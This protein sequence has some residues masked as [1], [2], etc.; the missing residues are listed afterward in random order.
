MPK[1]AKKGAVYPDRLTDEERVAVRSWI[2]RRYPHL[3]SGALLED[4]EER[5]LDKYRASGWEPCKDWAAGMRNW[6]RKGIEFG[7]VAPTS[8][9]KD[10]YA[11]YHKPA[12]LIEDLAADLASGKRMH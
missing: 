10:Y 6:L 8:A 5:M 2:K 3:D 1:K 9:A 4:Q 11:P 7:Q 12:K